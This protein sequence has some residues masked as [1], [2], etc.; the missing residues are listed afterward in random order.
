[1]LVTSSVIA[2]TNSPLSDLKT[3]TDTFC[4]AQT[5]NNE[6]VFTVNA[7]L[8]TKDELTINCPNM[9]DFSMKRVEDPNDP[10][11]FLFTIDAAKNNKAAPNTLD[12]DGKADIGMK[13]VGIN[14]FPANKESTE[15]KHMQ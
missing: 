1:M 12:C 5:S 9:G 14:C 3:F 10:G 2:E 8:F 4:N 7:D 13:V 6:M 15:H 11:H